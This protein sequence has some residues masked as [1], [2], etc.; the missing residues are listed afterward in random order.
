MATPPPLVFPTLNR[1]CPVGPYASR[2]M[3]TPPRWSFL[4]LTDVREVGAKAV[5][6]AASP[7]WPFLP[8]ADAPL[9]PTRT[10][11]HRGGRQG[12][13]PRGVTPLLLPTLDRR[14]PIDPSW[15]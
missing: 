14:R 7:H 4:P 6:H 5:S 12:R 11:V 8:L 2:A 3:A 15:P 10:T 1:R 9:V 13:K